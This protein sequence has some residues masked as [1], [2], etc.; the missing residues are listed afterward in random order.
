M[1]TLKKDSIEFLSILEGNHQLLKG[2]HWNSGCKAEHLLTDDI[3]EAILEYEDKIA[4]N[5]MGNGGFRIGV[6]ELKTMLPS[7]KS[8]TDMLNELESDVKKFKTTLVEDK[9]AGIINILDDL[10]TDINTWRY[11]KTFN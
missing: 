1:S 9:H 8:L 11:L 3:D 7:A 4:E 10:L 2:L 6:G 5:V